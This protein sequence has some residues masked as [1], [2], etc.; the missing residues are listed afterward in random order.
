LELTQLQS[1]AH[2]LHG[3]FADA[4]WAGTA[5][6]LASAVFQPFIAAVSEV[7]GPRELLFLSLVLFTAGST[8][9]G[10]AHN[11]TVL[12]AGRSVQGIG[13]GGI[14]TLVQS[15]FAGMIPL[16][17][18][19]K[20]FSLVLA[21]WALG[22]VSGPLI[23]GVFVQKSSFRW[24]FWINLPFCGIGLVLIPQVVKATVIKTSLR[25]SLLRIDWLGGFLFISSMTS[26]LI[27][28]SWAGV[29]FAWISYQTLVPAILGLVGIS[30]T[31]LWE[32]FGASEPF[33]QRTLFHKWS[34]IAAYTCAFLQGLMVS[35]LQ[36][37]TF[38]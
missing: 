8:I 5:Y 1:L 16:R 37:L 22:T 15:I 26:L 6:L 33:L 27:G 23:G 13:G 36:L 32:L 38:V 19:P 14:I 35:R 9:C 12:L 17:Q 20:W 2:D 18:R 21:A 28:L 25:N 4:F 11:F 34:L 30:A 3:T 7:L 10:I 31:L 24:A 29:Q